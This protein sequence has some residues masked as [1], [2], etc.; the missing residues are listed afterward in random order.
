MKENE[1]EEIKENTLYFLYRRGEPKHIQAL[2]ENG[3]LYINTIDSIRKCDQNEDR[4]D[5]Y[6]GI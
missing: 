5:A 3:D 2:Y 6:D 1:I 4:S